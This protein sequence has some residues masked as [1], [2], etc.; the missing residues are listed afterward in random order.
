MS[1]ILRER[2]LAKGGFSLWLDYYV[3]GVRTSETLRGK[4]GRPL[5]LTGNKKRDYEIKALAEA[6]RE[7]REKQLFNGVSINT[8]KKTSNLKEILSLYY[9]RF[10]NYKTYYTNKTILNLFVR[11]IG[12]NISIKDITKQHADSFIESQKKRNLSNN[13]LNLYITYM[14]TFFKWCLEKEY[15]SMNPMNQI[16]KFKKVSTKREYLTFEEIERFSKIDKNLNTKSAF[17]FSCY[18][19]LRL[20]DIRE[21]KWSNIRGNEIYK[22]ISKTGKHETLPIN[23]TAQKILDSKNKD[24][25]FVFEL[26][27]ENKTIEYQIK[28]ICELAGINKHITYHC[29]R[30]TFATI[31][32][33][34]G[35][36]IYTVS[37]LLGHSS[38]SMTEVYSN[39]INQNKVNAINSIPN[40][41][42]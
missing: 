40:L 1:V 18:T 26:P 10:S 36:D 21:L 9:E 25:V 6:I 22:K 41:E 31:L 30:H 28:A 2:K 38:V 16:K 3:E 32:L 37:K 11:F 34:N 24:S 39:L 12:E 29:S 15:I 17:L 14:N 13:T 7:E 35:V 42:Y 27:K 33:T 5:K 23:K 4:N 19:G 20:N 8:I